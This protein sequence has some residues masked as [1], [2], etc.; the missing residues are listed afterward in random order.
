MQIIIA[1]ITTLS[2]RGLVLGLTS[3]PFIINAFVGSNI[4]ASVLKH[5]GWRWGC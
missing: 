5:L 4:S 1:D 3:A 2:Y